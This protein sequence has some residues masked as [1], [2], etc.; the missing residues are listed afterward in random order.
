M[1]LEIS[2]RKNIGNLQYLVE[3]KHNAP[4]QPMNFFKSQEKIENIFRLMKMKT[5]AKFV[6]KLHS[7]PYD[8][9]KAVFR[10]KL[11]AIN[12]CIKNVKVP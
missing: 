3:I 8:G 6:L 2:S 1:K 7:K 4:K 5:V 11:I 12:A 10:R 9:V